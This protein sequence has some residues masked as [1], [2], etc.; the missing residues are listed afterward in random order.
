LR[1][2][3]F[4]IHACSLRQ[5][6]P[7]F[8]HPANEFKDTLVLDPLGQSCQQPLVIDP[9][10]EFRQI[11]VHNGCVAALQMFP[12]LRYRGLR[13]AS[14]AEAVAAVVKGRLENRFQHLQ[15]RLLHPPVYHIGNP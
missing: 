5:H 9:V 2:P 6:H 1:R 4:R 14:T 13:P 15:N 11:N 7:G 8:E 10:E 3:L 12:R